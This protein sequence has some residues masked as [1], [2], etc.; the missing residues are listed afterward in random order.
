MSSKNIRRL[1]TLFLVV[2]LWV[3][4]ALTTKNFV[5]LR[6]TLQ[7]LKESAFVG[8]IAVGMCFVMVGG[9]IDLSA[10]GIVCLV[11]ILC[12]RLSFISG[13]PGIV[14]LLCGVVIGALIGTFNGFLV[15][16]LHLTEFVATLASGFV[17]S[18]LGLVLA[19]HLNGTLITKSITNESF[20]AIGKSIGGLYW[21]TVVWLVVAVAAMIVMT[22][23]EVRHTYLR[24]GS[25]AKS[26]QM[27]GVN[28]SL[29]KATG[30]IICGATA[31]LA[32]GMQVAYQ[33]AAS[34]TL[35]TG[36]EFQAIA[37][38]VV[39]G[40]VLGGGKG[41]QVGAGL[42]ALFMVLILNGLNKYGL[43]S[44]WQY[45]AE[46]VI[47]VVATAF[48]SSFNI[49]MTKRLEKK[50]MRKAQPTQIKAGGVQ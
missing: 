27:S 45:V 15:T 23:N 16:R 25:N 13:I 22:R 21:I 44:A 35:G 7:L 4:F 11:A 2:V 19:F 48:D 34:A 31:G 43:S 8:L 1:I 6:N 5:T 49:L 14:V 46:G 37:A 47:I 33:S 39:G 28:N 18:G 32:S 40:V 42:G 30:F 29:I 9:G 24:P 10:G 20:L 41:D 36:Y 26:A 50:E 3:V 12:S 17:Y 38:C